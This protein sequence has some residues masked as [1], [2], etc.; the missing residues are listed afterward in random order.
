MQQQSIQ[1]KSS[2]L[3]KS[4]SSHSPIRKSVKTQRRWILITMKSVCNI[5]WMVLITLQ[6]KFD[7][8][9]ILGPH[10][11]NLLWVVRLWPL[12]FE[13]FFCGAVCL[14][15]LRRTACSTAAVAWKISDCG[16][17]GPSSPHQSL[18]QEVFDSKMD[19]KKIITHHLIYIFLKDS[20]QHQWKVPPQSLSRRSQT[21]LDDNRLG[22][23]STAR[24]GCSSWWKSLGWK[25]Y[26][27]LPVT[28]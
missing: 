20:F 16:H 9:K 4:G 3:D 28:G 19:E 7:L 26:F 24:G 14:Q 27:L 23:C 12:P 15:C 21:S 22:Y 8:L 25:R 11:S 18:Q 1:K 13:P 5:F 10:G 6:T 17:L 2:C